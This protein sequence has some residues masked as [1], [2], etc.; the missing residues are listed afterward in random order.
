MVERQ[1]SFVANATRKTI[2]RFPLT[3]IAE[4]AQ[5]LY[6][7]QIGDKA[8]SA[9]PL[10]GFHGARVL[11]IVSDDD[12]STY[13]VIYTTVDKNAIWVLHAFQKKS[14]RG[15]STPHNEIELVRQRLKQVE[16]M[17]HPT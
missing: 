11:E 16:R 2:A 7:A 15:I 1:L 9:K 17:S 8:D 5:A 10:K 6:L 3:V 12:G 13:R 14:K 4:V